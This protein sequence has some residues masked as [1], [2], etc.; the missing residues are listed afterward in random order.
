MLLP[1]Q[2]L[3]QYRQEVELLCKDALL[4]L[5]SPESSKSL[6][7]TSLT[8][9]QIETNAEVVVTDLAEIQQIHMNSRDKQLPARLLATQCPKLELINKLGTEPT[10]AYAK[11]SRCG[12]NR[13]KFT[14]AWYRIALAGCTIRRLSVEMA[15]ALHVAGVCHIEEVHV[16]NTMRVVNQATNWFADG[17]IPDINES[18]L[19]DLKQRLNDPS[20]EQPDVELVETCMAAVRRCRRPKSRYYGIQILSLLAESYEKGIHLDE[21][22]EIRRNMLPP[23]TSHPFPAD[24]HIEGWRADVRL[25]NYL[26]RASLA[27]N[28][29]GQFV[30]INNYYLEHFSGTDQKGEAIYAL[31]RE[32]LDHRSEELLEYALKQLKPTSPQHSIFIDIYFNWG[33]PL[34]IKGIKLLLLAIPRLGASTKTMAIEYILLSSVP[35]LFRT[36]VDKLIE[37][38][39]FLTRKV[40]LRLANQHPKSKAVFIHLALSGPSGHRGK[41]PSSKEG[42]TA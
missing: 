38:E 11:I 12:R 39:P 5:Y 27:A 18:T 32:C 29:N 40:A 3:S 26:R 35:D 1:V 21:L 8:I 17:V 31:I 37:Q 19:S 41:Q 34:I 14:G 28:K 9:L 10:K 36:A 33:Q 20:S 16:P 23:R 24:L 6:K 15:Q 2:S 25:W 42:A 4:V 22:F 13:L 7:A 30:R